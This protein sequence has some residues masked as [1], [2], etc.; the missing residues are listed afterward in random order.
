[1]G[2]T[3][4][5]SGQVAWLGL[6]PLA[7]GNLWHIGLGVPI[8]AI[9]ALGPDIDHGGSTISHRVWGPFHWRIG[10]GI[11]RSL[12]G[13]R[14]GAHSFLSIAVVF[15]L[16]SLTVLWEPL[17]GWWLPLAYTLGWAC[18]IL[19]D[20]LT[21]HGVGLLYP[22]SKRRF[23]LASINTGGVF[24]LIIRGL[25]HAARVFLVMSLAGISFQAFL[26]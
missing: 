15:C 11:G 25:L 26:Q 17:G 1:M 12:G 14:M 20:V 8:A 22:Y 23:R 24:E 6:A 13:H 7:T 3:H 10:T 16:T 2:R 9:A 5:L 18:H 4:F 21:E 19:G